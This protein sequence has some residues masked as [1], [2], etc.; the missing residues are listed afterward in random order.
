MVR[1]QGRTGRGQKDIGEK[2]LAGGREG[3]IG[4]GIDRDREEKLATAH[5]VQKTIMISTTFIC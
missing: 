2:L 4:R 3:R 5:F 1:W